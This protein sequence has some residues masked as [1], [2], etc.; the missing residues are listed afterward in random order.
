M[1]C[2]CPHCL[3]QIE[4]CETDY[5]PGASVWKQCPA[6]KNFFELKVRSYKDL[7]EAPEIRNIETP[8]ASVNNSSIGDNTQ[9]SAQPN[10][11]YT[12]PQYS[13]PQYNSNS[14][15][16]NISTPSQPAPN[17][18]SGNSWSQP[19]PSTP[20]D[21]G[22]NDAASQPNSNLKDDKPFAHSAT[23]TRESAP[24][25]S[26]SSS[27][28][29]APYRQPVAPVVTNEPEMPKLNDDTPIGQPNGPKPSKPSNYLWLSIF[30]TVC[31]CMPLGIAGIVEGQKV[32]KL[33]NQGK[34]DEAAKVSN[35]TKTIVWVGIIF[36]LVA[37]IV[38]VLNSINI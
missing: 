35:N 19:T 16:D 9:P 23:P 8:V 31:C 13:T 11:V 30:C 28:N 5:E 32:N 2:K 34:Y 1:K 6:C 15:D 38:N 20:S 21:S 25:S 33:Y 18:N 27:N 3:A 22:N 26:S 29:G 7:S 10:P 14:F 12:T 4:Y 37:G 36:G 24:S 17:S